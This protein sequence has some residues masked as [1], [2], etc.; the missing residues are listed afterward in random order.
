V[1]NDN[2]GLYHSMLLSGYRRGDVW[3]WF[4]TIRDDR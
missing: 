4:A 3:G 2:D 1:I